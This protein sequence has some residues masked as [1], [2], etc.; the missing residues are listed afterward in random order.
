[1][2]YFQCRCGNVLFFEN[3]LCVQCGATVGYDPAADAMVALDPQIP[4]KQCQ[5]GIQHGV[6]NWLVPTGSPNPLCPSCRLNRTI[7]ALNVPANLDAWHKIEV[8]KRRVLYTLAGLGFHPPSKLEDPANGL[9]FD[10]LD[11]LPGGKVMTGHINGVITL[12]VAEGIDS[13]R[14]RRRGALGE[15]Y[16]T[17]IGHFRHEFGHYYWNRFFAGL[18]DDDPSMRGF[19]ELFGDER[20]DYAA[21]LARRYSNEPTPPPPPDKFISE[22]AAV[23]PW[24]DWAETW[25]HYLHIIEGTETV[26]NFG[27]SPA[28]VPLPF[29]PFTQDAV[30]PPSGIDW[31]AQEQARFLD[32]LNGWSKLAP[33][34]NEVVASLG[35]LAFYPFVFSINIARKIAFVHF[36]AKR[37][38]PAHG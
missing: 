15:L 31:P 20:E 9:T 30:T 14:E 3:S 6:C 34:L 24:E 27:I 35:H 11:P 33:A 26:R 13:E 29:T 4:L 19:R 28:E 10:F 32:V 18:P 23:H 25:A 12:A 8:A 22:Y 16:R 2:R 36:I 38:L 5:N 21:A 7:P 1:M 37:G 17:L